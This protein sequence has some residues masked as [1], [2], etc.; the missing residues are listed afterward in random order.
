MLQVQFGPRVANPTTHFWAS[1]LLLAV[2]WM[3][4]SRRLLALQSVLLSTMP[5]VSMSDHFMH[6]LKI[7]RY[8]SCCPRH[9]CLPW[10]EAR[11]GAKSHQAISR[12]QGSKQHWAAPWLCS[13]GDAL[14]PPCFALWYDANKFYVGL[15]PQFTGL[16]RDVAVDTLIPQGDDLPPL[17]VQAG[18]RIWASFKNAH[19]DVCCPPKFIMVEALTFYYPPAQRIPQPHYHRPKSP[20]KVI[21]SKRCRIPWMRWCRVYCTDHR[22]NSQSSVQIAECTSCVGWC[23]EIVGVHGNCEWDWDQYV[24]QAKWDD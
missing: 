24:Y 8:D 11:G 15:N 20:E 6:W 13:R 5:K 21:Q 2:L 17:K 23:W 1:W 16:W 4:W 22:W 7:D 18:D 12:I 10:R 19:L 9:W 3:S 14:V